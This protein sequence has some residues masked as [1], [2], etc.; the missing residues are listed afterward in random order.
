MKD[1]VVLV[2]GYSDVPDSLRNWQNELFKKRLYS[3]V[4]PYLILENEQKKALRNGTEV[5]PLISQAGRHSVKYKTITA[6]G[7]GMPYYGFQ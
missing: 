3:K 4:Y 5:T 7:T 1:Q 2:Y 6:G